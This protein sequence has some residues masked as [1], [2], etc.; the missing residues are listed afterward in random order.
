MRG[1][2]PFPQFGDILGGGLA[3]AEPGKHPK[4]AHGALNNAELAVFRLPQD[5]RHHDK[6]GETKGAGDDGPGEG[7]EGAVSEPI[8]QR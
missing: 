5:A 6:G 3:Q 1:Q 7:P 8:A 2:A 4:H